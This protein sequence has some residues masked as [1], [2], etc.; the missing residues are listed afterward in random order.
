M[1]K[2]ILRNQLTHHLNFSE[3]EADVYLA[4]LSLGETTATNIAIKAGIKRTSVH[5]ILPT[6][7]ERGLIKSSRQGNKTLY[8]VGSVSDIKKR[9]IE[10][11]Q[12]IE[13]M[14]PELSAIHSPRAHINEVTQYEGKGGIRELYESIINNIPKGGELM[15]VFGNAEF[16]DHIPKS[17]IDFFSKKRIAKN[18]RHRAMIPKSEMSEY[19]ESPE[20]SPLREIKYINPQYPF[21]SEMRIY[22]DTVVIISHKDNYSALEIRNPNIA[23]M[24]KS[25]FEAW[26]KEAN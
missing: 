5:N 14:L 20:F 24:H 1:S 19:L 8:Y 3:K 9:L 25:L 15:T 13:A 4:I 18:I 21:Y 16:E 23:A 10:Q 26:W 2:T 12:I 6:L 11:E 22:G 7:K 17:L